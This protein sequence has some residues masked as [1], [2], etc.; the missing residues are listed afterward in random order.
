MINSAPSFDGS[1]AKEQVP[2]SCSPHLGYER[3]ADE[4]DKCRFRTTVSTQAKGAVLLLIFSR[5]LR[6]E[7][8]EENEDAFYIRV[9]K[10]R[11][12]AKSTQGWSVEVHHR[13][14]DLSCG[15]KG[16]HLKI[17]FENPPKC[18]NST[19][20]CPTVL[21]AIIC[22]CSGVDDQ[23]MTGPAYW[24]RRVRDMFKS[25]FF[26]GREPYATRLFQ[27]QRPSGMLSRTADFGPVAQTVGKHPR[28]NQ[29]KL[30]AGFEKL[31]FFWGRPFV[32]FNDC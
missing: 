13:S 16:K 11:C 5:T 21:A 27:W 4:C 30:T 1:G 14:N 26:Q 31:T 3:S 10:S 24:V 17:S 9:A 29:W 6:V 23:D 20:A 32:H 2:L 7:E 18:S 19:Q 28:N 22:R 15:L 25:W 12:W 8:E